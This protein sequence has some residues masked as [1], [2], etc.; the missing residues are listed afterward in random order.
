[1]ILNPNFPKF[2]DGEFL[3]EIDLYKFGWFF[4]ELYASSNIAKGHEGFFAPV[5]AEEL[6]WND[7][8]REYDYLRV[9]NLYVISSEGIPFVIMEQ[10]TL[11]L[12]ELDSFDIPLIATVYVAERSEAFKDRR[13]LSSNVFDE[14][15][16]DDDYDSPWEDQEQDEGLVA[17]DSADLNSYQVRLHWGDE[18]APDIAGTKRFDIVLGKLQGPDGTEFVPELK[19]YFASALP[20]LS[21]VVVSLQ[22]TLGGFLRLLF[23]PNNASGLDRELL[24]N[25][26]EL[27]ELKLTRA[28]LPV[29]E[30]VAESKAVLKAALGFFIRIAYAQDV[31]NPSYQA[32]RQLQGRML[33]YQL[34]AQGIEAEGPLGSLLDELK[35]AL[36]QS[37]NTGY[38]QIQ[39]FKALQLVF[40]ATRHEA[41]F[42][43]LSFQEPT[44]ADLPLRVSEPRVPRSRPKPTGPRIIDLN[45]DKD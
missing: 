21:S 8:V 3:S 31:N 10:Q 12:N 20:E 4:I 37:P 5:T 22:A 39:Y 42:A 32:F 19:A 2:E 18:T 38:E 34:E 13:F 23:N 35:D 1:M 14:Y 28:F 43:S 41:L 27:F 29:D 16:D 25:R 33:E 26:L 7:F 40:E 44:S 9:D 45:K 36:M 30:I 11:E 6:N 17:K 24:L 15:L